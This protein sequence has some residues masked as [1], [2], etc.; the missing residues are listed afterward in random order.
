MII[1]HPKLTKAMG[2]A[3]AR[4]A[5][6]VLRKVYCLSNFVPS[7]RNWNAFTSAIVEWSVFSCVI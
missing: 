1:S 6:V 7:N 3:R 5:P 4:N 2:R